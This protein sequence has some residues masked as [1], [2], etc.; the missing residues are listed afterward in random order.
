MA[1]LVAACSAS[2]LPTAPGP[3][4]QSFTAD[5][6]VLYPGEAVLLVPVFTGGAG[7]IE[8]DVGPVE[9]GRPVTLKPGTSPG[10]YVLRVTEGARS[11]VAELP[12]AIAYRHRL[13]PVL[14]GLPRT[15]HGAGLLPDGRVVLAGG[16]Y[17]GG[18][19]GRTEVW[20]PATGEFAQAGP[21]DNPHAEATTLLDGK[22]RL[23]LT[24]GHDSI[25]AL[26]SALVHAFDPVTGGWSELKNPMLQDRY[27]H[28][29]TLL[30]SGR[31][32]WPEATS[33]AGGRR[34]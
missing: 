13:D 28:S 31:S 22:G 27:Q 8:P 12:L 2:P 6:P 23:L 18:W 20:D 9:S 33:S 7:V 17:G 4:I 15:D 1:L 16:F 30:P 5:P 14:G 11:A 32:S 26:E 29:A 19:E 25:G 21:L 10:T 24:G 34:R 3:S